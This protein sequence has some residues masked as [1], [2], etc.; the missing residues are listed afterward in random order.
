[1]ELPTANSNSSIPG[2]D[3]PPASEPPVCHPAKPASEAGGEF[4][5]WYEF[6]AARRCRY[7]TVLPPWDDRE[8]K[9]AFLALWRVYG[10]RRADFVPLVSQDL[11]ATAL[12]ARTAART[13]PE[14]RAI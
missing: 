14:E 7:G 1:L 3:S 2:D 13:T 4:E 11:R 9:H 8:Q 5:A 6:Q 12:L 10:Y